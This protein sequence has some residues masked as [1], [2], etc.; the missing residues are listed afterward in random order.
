[1]TISTYPSFTLF[2]AGAE[3]LIHGEAV[4]VTLQSL[5]AYGPQ[6]HHWAVAWSGGKAGGSDA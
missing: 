2:V 4:T 1:M 3:R 6:R 5:L